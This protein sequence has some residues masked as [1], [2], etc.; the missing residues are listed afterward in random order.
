M[1]TIRDVFAALVCAIAAGGAAAQSYQG[2]L[3]GAVRDA[4]A[5]VPGADVTLVSEETGASRATVTNGAG[6]YAFPSV[7]PGTYTV[8]A[9]LTGFKTFEDHGIRIG[10]Q[11]FVTLDLRLQVGRSE[12]R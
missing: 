10:T 5:V 8:R 1:T 4:N 12:S 6:E 2:G 3:R 7:V 11:E 9:S